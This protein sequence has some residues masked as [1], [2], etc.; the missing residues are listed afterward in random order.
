MGA[1]PD[2]PRWGKPRVWPRG[3]QAPHLL[4]GGG[5]AALGTPEAA[6]PFPTLIHCLWGSSGLPSDRAW[7]ELEGLG[8]L[9]VAVSAPPTTPREA[10]RPYPA[11]GSLRAPGPGSGWTPPVPVHLSPAAPGS[12]PPP[13]ASGCSSEPPPPFCTGGRSHG[14]NPH[15]P[16]A[17]RRRRTPAPCCGPR[18]AGLREPLCRPRSPEAAKGVR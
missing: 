12:Q 9:A 11:A 2:K 15:C 3:P 6:A 5:G 13:A 18:R 10:G 7:G 1:A 8:A 14:T 17:R 16:R 4:C